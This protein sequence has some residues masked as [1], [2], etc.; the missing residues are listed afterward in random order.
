MPRILSEKEMPNYLTSERM[1]HC[2]YFRDRELLAAA[3][4]RLNKS[5]IKEIVKWHH[6]LHWKDL[7]FGGNNSWIEVHC[8]PLNLWNDVAFEMVG[9]NL[10][11]LL[12][13]GEVTR[14]LS[15]IDN[16]IIKI[17][18]SRT[19]FFWGTMEFPCWDDTI[20][21]GINKSTGVFLEEFDKAAGQCTGGQLEDEGTDEG[22]LLERT[23]DI[24][25]PL[26]IQEPDQL[27]SSEIRVVTDMYINL[28]AKRRSLSLF[29]MEANEDLPTHAEL[30]VVEEASNHQ[31]QVQ[32]S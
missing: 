2:S 14:S 28:D 18:G 12:E 21:F 30:E 24:H 22:K 13:V 10:G 23:G 16:A 31:E 5:L 7:K 20:P 26:H 32:L 27:A 25:R 11:G 15:V 17:R 1:G 4:R 29:E 8:L 6:V 3:L 9:K 19:S